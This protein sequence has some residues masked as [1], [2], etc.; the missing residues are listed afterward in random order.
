[1]RLLVVIGYE[2]SGCVLLM[3]CGSM[4]CGLFR[5]AL[6]VVSELPCLV[7]FFGAL[8]HCGPR[9]CKSL[10]GVQPLRALRDGSDVTKQN[11]TASD[12]T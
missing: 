9:L 7:L 8:L 4:G 2:L 3:R 5:H 12:H 6:R 11:A 1:M 10:F